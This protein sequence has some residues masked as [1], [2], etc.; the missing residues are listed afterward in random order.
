M[1]DRKQLEDAIVAL[2]SQR[3]ILG[4]AVVDSSIELIRQKLAAMQQEVVSGTGERKLVT[5]MFA[6]IAGFTAFSEKNDPEVVR[7]L[8]NDCFSWM[9][10]FIEKYDGVV[11]SLLVMKSW[12]YLAHR[13]LMRMTLNEHC[14]RR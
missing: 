4:D 1:N 7:A 6:D 10:P 3:A 11:R 8:I 2:E 13:L 14:A 5:V 9:V 12:R